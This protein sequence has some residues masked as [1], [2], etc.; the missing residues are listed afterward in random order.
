M[1]HHQHR[2]P[3][4]QPPDQCGDAVNVL[5]AH[6]GHRLIEQQQVGIQ[7]QGGGDLQ[8]ALAATGSSTAVAAAS[9]ASPLRQQRQ[10]LLVQH[11]EDEPRRQEMKGDAE[12]AL[13]GDANV[14]ENAD[15]REHCRNLEQA[16]TI[17]CGQWHAA[18]HG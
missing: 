4:G 2:P 12:L 6:T 9:S 3:L 16:R 13:Q 7:R 10:R 5:A 17:P 15:V 18:V 8:G 11:V 14:V 1:L